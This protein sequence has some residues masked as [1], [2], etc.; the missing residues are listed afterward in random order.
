MGDMKV[1]GYTVAMLIA[2]SLASTNITQKDCQQTLCPI[3]MLRLSSQSPPTARR[4]G[5]IGSG[6]RRSR[7]LQQGVD[8]LFEMIKRLTRGRP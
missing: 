5:R 8:M 3:L 6:E 4:R 1:I 2:G 7:S